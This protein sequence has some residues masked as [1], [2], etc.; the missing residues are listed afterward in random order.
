MSFMDDS[1][2][3]RILPKS[4]GRPVLNKKLYG[5]YLGGLLPVFKTY[6]MT[7]HEV[8]E[9]G[10]TIVVHAS[11]SGLSMADTTFTNEYNITMHFVPPENGEGLPKIT[12][13]KEFVDSENI[14]KFFAEEREKS[15]AAKRNGI[16]RSH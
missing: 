5:E 10:D 14:V 15:A 11:A 13:V 9:A 2:E 8:I 16:S 12:F 3:H 6:K 7:L 4:L 1:L